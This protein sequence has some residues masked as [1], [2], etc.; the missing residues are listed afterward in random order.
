[1]IR[2][3]IE[4][5]DAVDVIAENCNGFIEKIHLNSSKKCKRIR[6]YNHERL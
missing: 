6:K 5:D 2:I 1:M 3:S 4:S